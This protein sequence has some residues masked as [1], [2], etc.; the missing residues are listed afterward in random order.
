MV[1]EG[2][3]VDQGTERRRAVSRWTHLVCVACWNTMHPLTPAHPD[4]TDSM[5]DSRDP[6]CSCGRA[7]G[8]GIYIR[9][10]PL[11]MQC[12]GQ[13]PVHKHEGGER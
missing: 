4:H 6:C 7:T 1:E 8:S 12:V 3:E 10:N 9:Q 5:N 11:T 13:G 2:V